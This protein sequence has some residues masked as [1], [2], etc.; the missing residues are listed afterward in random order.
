MDDRPYDGVSLLPIIDGTVSERSKPIA[1]ESRRQV[2]LIGNRY[3]LYSGNEGKTCELY[4][5]VADPGETTDLAEQFPKRVARMR[6]TLAA[7]R[8]SCR[9]GLAGDDYSLR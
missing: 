5:L 2:S 8:N 1:F 9:A 3:K 4:D 6:E 7:W